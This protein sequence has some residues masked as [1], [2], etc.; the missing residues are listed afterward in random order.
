MFIAKG[1]DPKQIETEA[2]TVAN[3]PQEIIKSFQTLEDART[4][5]FKIVKQ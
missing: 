5:I 3:Y 4:V 2:F 1:V